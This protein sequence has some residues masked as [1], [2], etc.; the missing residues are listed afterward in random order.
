MQIDY[1]SMALTGGA[2]TPTLSYTRQ[3]TLPFTVNVQPSAR[4]TALH[5]LP[6]SPKPTA[7]SGRH[8]AGTGFTSIGKLLE[9]D[10]FLINSLGRVGGDESCLLVLEVLNTSSTQ[11]FEID[12]R[13]ASATEEETSTRLPSTSMIRRVEAG[14]TVNMVLPL[15]RF[16]LSSEDA[17][18]PIPSLSDKQFVV[19]RDRT[20]AVETELFWYRERLIRSL[21]LNW[22]EADASR[23]GYI[24]MSRL[25][26]TEAMLEALK[27]PE[28]SIKTTL[29]VGDAGL[30]QNAQ[31]CWPVQCGDFVEVVMRVRNRG[32]EF[33]LSRY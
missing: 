15:P 12:L 30:E 5:I 33:A 27:L 2:S 32:C 1:A 31:G 22:R 17:A 9:E 26:L 13:Q 29:S 14:A 28:L 18:Q 7:A 6:V 24:D 20:T 8:T 10:P 19:G 21:S 11:V 16:S 4:C 3:V 25:S 23:S